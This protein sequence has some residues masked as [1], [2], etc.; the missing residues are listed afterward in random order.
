MAGKEKKPRPYQGVRDEIREQHMKAKDM[1]FKERLGY[2]WYYY[3]IH[4]LVAVFA[5]FVI[6]GFVHDIA[7][8]KDYIFNSLMLNSYQ[9]SSEE[10][11]RAF[12]EYAELDM[13]TYDCFI[14]TSSTL[15][16]RSMGQYDIATVQKILATIQTGDLDAV[17]YDSEIFNNYSEHEMFTDLRT[18]LT[19]DELSKY[20]DY[21]YYIDYA[22]VLR[23]QEEEAENPTGQAPSETQPTQEALDEALALETEKH[24]HPEDMETPIPVGVFLEDSPFAQKTGAYLQKVPVFGVISTSQRPD[25]CKKYLEFLWDDSV[26]FTQFVTAG[27]VY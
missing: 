12:G 19:E 22:E 20:E 21:L 23:I 25:T 26:D 3:K 14:D 27:P 1:T 24:R 8:S 15:S 11:S 10:F 2:F 5:V 4:T 9:L 16:L 18:V 6:I 7:T 13:E 17:V